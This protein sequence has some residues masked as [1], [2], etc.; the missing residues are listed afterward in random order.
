M[1]DAHR[2][3]GDGPVTKPIEVLIQAQNE[4]K[5]GEELAEA[6]SGLDRAASYYDR[7]DM[8]HTASLVR[9]GRR[10]VSRALVVGDWDDR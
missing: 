8:P 10:R 3:V 5:A 2:L 7:A 9:E 4:K 1:E 6:L